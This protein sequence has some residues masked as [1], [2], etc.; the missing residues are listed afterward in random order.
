VIEWI[1]WVEYSARSFSHWLTAEASTLGALFAVVVESTFGVVVVSVFVVVFLVAVVATNAV[2]VVLALF[3]SAG[4]VFVAAPAVAVSALRVVVLAVVVVSVVPALFVAVATAFALVLVVVAEVFASLVHAVVEAVFVALAA[5]FAALVPVVVA[6][7]FAVLA[8]ATVFVVLAPATVV[9]VPF[10]AALSSAR[11]LQVLGLF[12]VGVAVSVL[13]HAVVVEDVSVLPLFGCV[14]AVL[15]GP[16]S[17]FAAVEVVV[18]VAQCIPVAPFC[19]YLRYQNLCCPF[20]SAF[21]ASSTLL[22]AFAF[23]ALAP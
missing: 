1:Y 15:A 6:V 13:V 8:L 12:F 18:S 7:V 3:V 11:D 2:F 4:V 16:S 20:V 23:Q 10:A 17:A 21:P 9:L 14:F 19:V 5:V 22:D